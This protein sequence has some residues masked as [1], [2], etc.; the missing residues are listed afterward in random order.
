MH[1]R[2]LKLENSRLELVTLSEATERL[3]RKREQDR[4]DAFN[5][6]CTEQ[7]QLALCPYEQPGHLMH[8]LGPAP[9][10]EH[11]IP[12]KK[13]TVTVPFMY[14]KKSVRLRVRE[15]DRDV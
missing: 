11:L 15:R 14:I 13:S 12:L 4:V 3:R 10:F 6:A 5:K 2:E 8:Q 1:M 9:F 7:K